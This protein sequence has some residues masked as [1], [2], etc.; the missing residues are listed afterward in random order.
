MTLK[1]YLEDYA[2]MDTREKGLKVIERDFRMWKEKK[3]GRCCKE[4][5]GDRTGKK[6]FSFS[7]VKSKKGLHNPAGMGYHGDML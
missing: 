3:Q 4:S 6:R 5:E 2:S 1:E 7:E